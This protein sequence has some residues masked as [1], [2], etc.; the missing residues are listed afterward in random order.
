MMFAYFKYYYFL[1]HS[2]PMHPFSTPPKTSEK[3]TVKKG[4]IG[5]E[6]VN[7]IVNLAVPFCFLVVCM[8]DQTHMYSS[9]IS[10]LRPLQGIICN[11]E[12][13]KGGTLE[14]QIT[15]GYKK[16]EGFQSRL[17]TKWITYLQS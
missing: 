11:I 10:L 17:H 6:R 3:L 13:P 7:V 12:R 5:N 15:G 1:T 8:V 16:E 2:F 14:P 4:C 9:S